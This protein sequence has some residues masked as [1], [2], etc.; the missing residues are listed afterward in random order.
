MELKF[1][2]SVFSRWISTFFFMVGL[3]FDGVET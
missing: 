2:L 1:S 3:S